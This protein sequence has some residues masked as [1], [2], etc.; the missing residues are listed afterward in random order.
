[1][2]EATIMERDALLREIT[3]LDFMA[4]DLHLFLNTN[5]DDQ[6]A[7]EMY[8]DCVTRSKELHEEYEV[9]FGPLSAYRSL[10]QPG[11]KWNQEPWP[12][13]EKF[14]FDITEKL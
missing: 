1:M 12:W 4:L 10:G 8:N 2:G 13:E 5:P 14:N 3:I 7:L 6:E 11:W 9:A